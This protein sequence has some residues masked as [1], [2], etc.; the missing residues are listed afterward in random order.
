MAFRKLVRSFYRS[1]ISL[2]CF[3]DVSHSTSMIDDS[4]S[5]VVSQFNTAKS[6]SKTALPLCSLDTL[7][8]TGKTIDGT[9]SFAPSDPALIES[10][11]HSVV[12]TYVSQPII[13]GTDEN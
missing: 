2:H 3:G 4:S 11:V 10:S 5:R 13:S 6:I 9:V 12:G 8:S 7:L 1:P